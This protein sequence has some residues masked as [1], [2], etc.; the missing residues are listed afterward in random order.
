[1][2][3]S[4]NLVD[5]VR[6]DEPHDLHHSIFPNL[7]YQEMQR[8]WEE[9]ASDIVIDLQIR[10]KTHIDT[11]HVPK[12][13]EPLNASLFSPDLHVYLATRIDESVPHWNIAQKAL[14]FNVYLHEL[15]TQAKNDLFNRIRDK[16]N[17][18]KGL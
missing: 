2:M 8:Q 3:N 10:V 6:L 1:M 17:R 9:L 14:A 15:Y 16:H 5:Y 18:Q 4:S 11:L 13:D 7:T 12:M